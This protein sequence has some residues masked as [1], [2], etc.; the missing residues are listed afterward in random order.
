MLNSFLEHGTR[1]LDYVGDDFVRF[2][3]EHHQA[4]LVVVSHITESEDWTLDLAWITLSNKVFL[5]LH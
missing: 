5:T 3:Y 4:L 2:N 1:K